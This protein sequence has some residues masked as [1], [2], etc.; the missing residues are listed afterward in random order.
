M[1]KPISVLSG[2]VLAIV[3]Y[4]LCLSLGVNSEASLMAGIT[5][6]M[7]TWWILESVSIYLTAFIPA[8]ALPILGILPMNE[9]AGVYMP[10]I[11][12]LF[13]GGFL[14]AFAM[15]KCRL[16]ERI[17]LRII[18]TIGN[19]PSRLLLSVMLAGFLLSMWILNTAAVVVLLPAVLAIIQHLKDNAEFKT[20][21]LLGL[22]YASSIGGMATL[23]GTAPNLYFADFY[24]QYNHG[25]DDITFFN[26]FVFA[27]PLSLILFVIAYQLL[28]W[29]YRPKDVKE[30]VSLEVIRSDYR[31][32][33]SM[34][35]DEKWVGGSFA[36]LVLLW[37]TSRDIDL[38]GFEMTGWLSFLPAGGYV[39]ESTLAMLVSFVLFLIPSNQSSGAILDWKDAQRI[40]IGIIFL[41]GG[42]FALAKGF[43]TSGLSEILGNQLAIAGELN[44]WLAVIL[45]C[46]FMTFF[47]EIA[48]NTASIVLILPIVASLSPSLPYP[49]LFLMLPLTITASCAFMLPVA[50]PPN[51]IVFGSEMINIKDMV[52]TGVVLNVVL[53]IIIA[54]YSILMIPRIF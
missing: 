5:V 29:M 47:T 22:A 33:G 23:I 20:P 12:F 7:A 49:I 48:S 2:P 44:L 51:T 24:S 27:A 50:T 19:S 15:E 43:D 32:L 37:F 13:I 25:V 26:W 40:P 53:S 6:W 16:H 10:Q 8:F 11:T 1:K 18:L 41:F 46:V 36:I 45:L 31:Q 42:G 28:K 17:A 54:T 30:A 34:S 9:L 4:L 21:L 38:G 35:R 39:R 14:M 3:S 52:R